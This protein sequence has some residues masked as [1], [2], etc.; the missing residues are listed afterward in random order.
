[1]ITE[2]AWRNHIART[3]E[4]ER[5]EAQRTARERREWAARMSLPGENDSDDENGDHRGRG[6]AI[7]RM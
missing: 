1:M 7:R 2:A 3:E 4:L 5:R 6:R